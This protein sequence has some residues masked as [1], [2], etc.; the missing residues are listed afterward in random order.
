MSTYTHMR[1]RVM[2]G[3]MIVAG[4]PFGL[5]CFF[6]GSSLA[7]PVTHVTRSVRPTT[8]D[9]MLGKP[10]Q[11]NVDGATVNSALTGYVC[12]AWSTP[13]VTTVRCSK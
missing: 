2:A 10:T 6:A 4:L 7:P 3:A 9:Q 11:I 8:L 5:G 12:E 1:A 13:A